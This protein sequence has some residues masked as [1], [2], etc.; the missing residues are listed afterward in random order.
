MPRSDFEQMIESAKTS[1]VGK[2][3]CD[4]PQLKE[5]PSDSPARV[6]FGESRTWLPKQKHPIKS[7]LSKNVLDLFIKNFQNYEGYWDD[8]KFSSLAYYPKTP[9]QNLTPKPVVKT[10]DQPLGQKSRNAGLSKKQLNKWL[11]DRNKRVKDALKKKK[12]MYPGCIFQIT[13]TE[14]GKDLTPTF[15]EVLGGQKLFE[16]HRISRN[17][18]KK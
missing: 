14:S 10:P 3:S 12:I 1:C 6:L 18:R 7:R 11:W 16:I 15:G 9:G 5:D 2:L 13:N 17:I 8:S 4:S